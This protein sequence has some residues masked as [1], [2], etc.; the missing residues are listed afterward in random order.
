[1]LRLKIM[2]RARPV[3]AQLAASFVFL[4]EFCPYQITALCFQQTLLASNCH[5]TLL[6]KDER[7]NLLC[8]MG[9][10]RRAFGA[11][12]QFRQASTSYV[13]H[14]HLILVLCE[15][16]YLSALH[17]TLFPTES[18]FFRRFAIFYSLPKSLVN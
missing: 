5:Q 15:S 3:D 12:T 7:F 18:L 9:R 17:D 4:H 10:I 13:L 8:E 16:L 11:G 1:M 6:L 2:P 14:L